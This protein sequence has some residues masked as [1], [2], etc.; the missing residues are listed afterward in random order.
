MGEV[1]RVELPVVLNVNKRDN[2]TV[3]FGIRGVRQLVGRRNTSWWGG[4]GSGPK[5]ILT[6]SGYKDVETLFT[7]YQSTQYILLQYYITEYDT[8]RREIIL[9]NTRRP[10]FAVIL[11]G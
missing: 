5:Q 1:D 2:N 8:I 7:R 4:V 9:K 11:L 6:D 3:L 10:Y